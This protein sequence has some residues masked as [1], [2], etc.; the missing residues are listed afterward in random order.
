MQCWNEG[1]ANKAGCGE[2]SR[3]QCTKLDLVLSAGLWTLS[4]LPLHT[5][6]SADLDSRAYSMSLTPF[7][8]YDMQSHTD[9]NA[10][11]SRAQ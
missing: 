5:A 4:L 6:R 7:Q 1:A 9:Y 2:P 8:P 10:I 11:R 3:V